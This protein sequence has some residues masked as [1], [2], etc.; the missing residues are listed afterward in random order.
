ML[1]LVGESGSGKSTVA[2]LRPAPDRADGGDDPPEGHRH[3]APLAP[4]DASAAPRAAHRLPGPVLVA[5]PADDV[6][7]H[8]R[9]AAAPAPDRQGQRTRRARH[10]DPRRRRPATTSCAS[11]I[12]TSSRAAS[13][14]VSASRARLIVR[15][16]A[17]S[18][19]TSRS[20]R[21]TC[22]SRRRSSTC[23]ATSRTRSASRASSSHTTSRR[24]ST[25]AT[26]SPS[27]TS[28]RSSSWRRA[29]SCSTARS[30][31]TRRRCSRRRS[32]PIR[33]C[34]A[35]AAGRAR[36]RRPQPARAALGLPLPHPLPARGAVGSGVDRGGAAPARVRARAR[37]RLPSRRARP[38][39]SPT[40]G[41]HRRYRLG[42][43]SMSFTTR[44]ELRGTF[45]M[46][47]STHWLAS[48]AGMAVLEQGGNAFDAAV[49]AGLTLQVVEPHL[50]GPGG[51][52]PAL[53]WPAKSGEPLVLCAQ[54]P[55]PRAATI[56]RYRDEL[57]LALVPGTGPLAAVVPGAFGGWMAMLRDHGTLPLADVLRFAI[58]YAE[59]GYPV[60]P[61][62][63]ARSATSS[64]SSATSGRPPPRSTCR[65]RSRARCTA[66][67]SSPRPTG[68]SSTSRTDDVDAAH[69]L[70]VSRLRRG[71]D[72][73]ASRSA[74]GWTAR[75][76]GT[77]A[78]S[79][80]RTCAT[81]G[82]RTS[83]RSPSTTRA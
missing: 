60:L 11:A 22:R 46:V 21:S 5:Q 49:A 14:S 43:E 63:P 35:P 18:S 79:P 24:S 53:L 27:C 55:A 52:L 62:S 31:R 2:Q 78:C 45:G 48:A 3:H 25:S 4:G 61:R 64:R 36:R 50:N 20:R 37:G 69:R 72:A 8:R 29:P 17:C 38:S 15:A 74:S 42:R 34:S 23:C 67:R 51:D 26:A 77:P 10:G 7:R 71:G 65:R 32:S 1:G 41:G 66:T 83:S 47:A 59:D 76:S 57:G 13:A 33:Q 16:R 40:R 28:G 30:I 54:G 81:G 44:P 12:R 80:R 6:R 19:P 70:L 39:G 56:E 9:R 82:P 58:G 73:R 68:A 75:A